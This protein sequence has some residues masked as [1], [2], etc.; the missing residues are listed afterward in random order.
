MNELSALI[1][2]L[3]GIAATAWIGGIFFAYMALRPAANIVLEPP[4]RLALWHAAYR[5]F[6][7]WVWLCIGILLVTGYGDL[8]LRFNGFSS[9]AIYLAIMHIVGLIM[10][11]FFC[12]LYFSL[13]RALA[14]ALKRSD[15]PA[16]AK[17][18]NKMRPVMAINLSLGL[19]IVAVGISGSYF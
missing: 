10:V 13:Y 3:H 9:D 18:M 12:Y 16:A 1:Q 2:A 6:F 14:Q 11:G 17:V 7:P 5:H 19:L 15:I 4:L 8:F